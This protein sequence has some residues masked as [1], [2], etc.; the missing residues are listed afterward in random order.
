M[1]TLLSYYLFCGTTNKLTKLR[2]DE[3]MSIA[4]QG[5]HTSV[6]KLHAMLILEEQIKCKGIYF[7]V[8]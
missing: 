1:L 6:L 7:A 8:R 2:D 4:S 3:K 5:L